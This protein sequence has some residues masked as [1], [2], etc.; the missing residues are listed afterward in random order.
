MSRGKLLFVNQ[1]KQRSS[2]RHY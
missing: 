1:Y 2:R